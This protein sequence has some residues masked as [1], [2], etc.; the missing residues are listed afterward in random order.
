MNKE[1]LLALTSDKVTENNIN[2]FGRFDALRNS[3]DVEKARAY[4]EKQQG[5][6]VGVFKLNMLIDIHLRKFV[7]QT[8]NDLIVDE[9]EGSSAE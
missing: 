5:G 7:L 3:V 2:H 8:E 9:H 4:F 1:L 6:S